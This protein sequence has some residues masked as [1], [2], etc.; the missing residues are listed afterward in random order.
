VLLALVGAGVLGVLV[1]WVLVRP[2][3]GRPPT[4]AVLLTVAVGIMLQGL[5]VLIWTPRVQ[6][7]AALLGIV[8]K[9]IRVVP[10]AVISSLG[11]LGILTCLGALLALVVF[12]R[13]SRLGVQMLAA[14]ENP[15]LVAQRGVN[16]HRLI[17]LAW[18]LAAISAALAGVLYSSANRL[19]ASMALVGLKAFSAAM[20]GGMGSLAGVLPGAVLVAMAEVAAVQFVNPQL[21]EAVPFLLLL[22][23]LLVRPWGLYGNPEQIARV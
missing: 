20:V 5:V 4:S 2:M 19:E 13:R 7:P 15:L 14:A 11:G 9:P 21:G 1:Y 10:G 12:F 23:V 16:V 3:A 8:D 18:G 22:I 17:S 6:Y